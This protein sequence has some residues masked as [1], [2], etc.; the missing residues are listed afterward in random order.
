MYELTMKLSYHTKNNI[1]AAAA[2]RKQQLSSTLHH[3]SSLSPTAQEIT[4]A[5]IC[6]A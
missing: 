1:P 3:S 5:E 6:K 4:L 2:L